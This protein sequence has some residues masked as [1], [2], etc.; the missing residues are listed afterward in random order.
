MRKL[1]ADFAEHPLPKHAW[2]VS[3]SIGAH[4]FQFVVAVGVASGSSGDV[5]LAVAASVAPA[6]PPSPVEVAAVTAAHAAPPAHGSIDSDG[7]PAH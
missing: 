5:A 4:R 2:A 3:R 6:P 7:A 1:P